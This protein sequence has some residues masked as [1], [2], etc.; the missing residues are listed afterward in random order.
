LTPIPFHANL[1]S[2]KG[3]G[4]LAFFASLEPW[5][6]LEVWTFNSKKLFGEIKLC[7]KSITLLKHTDNGGLKE[8]IVVRYLTG[9]PLIINKTT[10]LFI[11]PWN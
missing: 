3:S 4:P 10:A 5:G 6:F 2:I 1:I 7:H 11:R 9:S 8:I